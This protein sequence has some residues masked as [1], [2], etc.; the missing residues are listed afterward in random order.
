MKLYN[1]LQG[2]PSALIFEHAGKGKA[3]LKAYGGI[4]FDDNTRATTAIGTADKAITP[5][6][7]GYGVTPAIGTTPGPANL[8]VD[9]AGIYFVTFSCSFT[10][11]TESVDFDFYV[12]LNGARVNPGSHSRTFTPTDSR[13]VSFSWIIQIPAGGVLVPTVH[14]ETGSG[15]S[16]TVED[17]SLMAL[18][19]GDL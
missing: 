19:V 14:A 16:L 15:R 9:T 7:A 10:A 11:A 8:T 18:Y 13:G 12:T 17:C 4:W 1:Q 5:P 6:L 3:M 2:W